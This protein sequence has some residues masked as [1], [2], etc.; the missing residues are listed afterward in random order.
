MDIAECH[1]LAVVEDACQAHGARYKGR[2]TGGLG[3]AA[4]FSFYPGK[5]LGAFSDGG[6]VTTN[7]AELAERVFML[8]NYGS[9]VKYHH[10][11]KGTNSRLDELQAAF[12]RVKLKH[13]DEWNNRRRSMANQYMEQLSD[14]EE[15][16][17]PSVHTYAESVWHLYVVR[18]SHRSALQEALARFGIASQI[19]YPI[20]PHLS[21]AYSDMNLLK[22]SFPVAEGIA[23]T[24]LSLPMGPHMSSEDVAEIAS[25]IMSL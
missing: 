22:G 15:L 3:H 5:N 9:K 25:V 1:G 13:L 20:S 12:L 24:V 17:L 16:I 18:H 6:A 10:E 7:N 8:R 2:K 4:A 19:H 11:I 14:C 21:A 23:E